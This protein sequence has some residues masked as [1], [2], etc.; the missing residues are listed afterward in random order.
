MRSKKLDLKKEIV[1]NL[2]STEGSQ[3]K[4]GTSVLAECYTVDY[5]YCTGVL[6]GCATVASCL[7][8]DETQCAGTSCCGPT[9]ADCTNLN[10]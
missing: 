6:G 10:C 8:Y 9:Y 1:A 3:V 7:C 4:G 5:Y 2:S